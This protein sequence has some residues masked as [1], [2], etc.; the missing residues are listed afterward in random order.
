M[1]PMECPIFE[2]LA[3]LQRRSGCVGVVSHIA[4]NFQTFFWYVLLVSG[5]GDFVILGI[6]PKSV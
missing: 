3:H 4:Q 6:A 2:L 5:L 1:H